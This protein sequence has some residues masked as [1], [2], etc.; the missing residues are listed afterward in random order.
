MNIY[1]SWGRDSANCSDSVLHLK[2]KNP[3]PPFSVSRLRA[4]VCCRISAHSCPS[5]TSLAFA[6][7]PFF[8]EVN[9]TPNFLWNTVQKRM[10]LYSLFIVLALVKPN[11]VKRC[12]RL[13]RGPSRA[14]PADPPRQPR[15]ARGRGEAPAIRAQPQYIYIYTMTYYMH[16]SRIPASW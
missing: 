13:Q 3:C 2:K 7:F 15:G 12:R 11:R 16:F 10:Y 14:P 4:A 1:V 9:L 5:Y 8:L 6:R